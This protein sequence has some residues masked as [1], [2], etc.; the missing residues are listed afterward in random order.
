MSIRV[1][2][3]PLIASSLVVSR[4]AGHGVRGDQIPTTGEH[5]GSFLQDSANLPADDAVEFRF[6][7]Q[8]GPT[9]GASFTALNE[10]GSFALSVPG[11]GTYT[12]TFQVWADGVSQGVAT[13]TVTVG[14]TGVTVTVEPAVVS[15]ASLD[16][17]PLAGDLVVQPG[18]AV[19]ESS[20]TL[21]GVVRGSFAVSPAPA[22]LHLHALDPV[23]QAGGVN[24]AVEP[25]VLALTATAAVP[26]RGDLAIAVPVAEVLLGALDPA[27]AANGPVIAVEPAVV[28]M[29]GLPPTVQRGALVV[30]P[31][32]A[33]VDL[34]ALAPIPH[35][36]DLV[37]TVQP[38]VLQLLALDPTPVTGSAVVPVYL[39][40]DL[41]LSHAVAL[42][43]R[44]S[45]TKGLN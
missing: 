1:D 21:G 3:A 28:A 16:P 29:L 2:S 12:W 13:A 40:L 45:H 42:D 27:I 5:G 6:E 20:A 39:V 18:A 30:A 15:L 43:T 14:A 23:V 17:V 38:A 33:R 8:T 4:Y 37:V 11:D 41:P 26:V 7:I 24:I 34:S 31:D 44:L 10:D 32:P 19:L 25:A 35:A 22:V 9:G 36:G